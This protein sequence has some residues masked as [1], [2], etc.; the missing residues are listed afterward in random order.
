VAGL[1]DIHNHILPGIDDG[2][3]SEAGAVAMAR[4]AVDAGVETIAATPHLRK[5]FPAVRV[6]EIAQRCEH[7][8]SLLGEHGVRLAV[9]PAAE[10]SLPWALRA[11]ASELRLASFAGRG[12]TILIETPFNVDAGLP[13][14]LYE[15]QRQCG[16]VILAHPERSPVFTSDPGQVLTLVDQGVVLQLNA[17]SFLAPRLRGLTPFLHALFHRRAVGVVA[18]DGHAATGNRS[19]GHL[20]AAR[21]L[22]GESIGEEGAA[23]LTHATPKALLAGDRLTM[24]LPT[25]DAFAPR[26]SLRSLW[27]K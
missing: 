15:V 23:I 12:S 17:E 11:D 6:D 9:F 20:A 8:Q 25:T 10:V 16:T 5:D 13:Q 18:S 26:R 14:L 27:R 3:S 22:L 2:P 21:A 1:V 19:V 24:S 4:A 7:L